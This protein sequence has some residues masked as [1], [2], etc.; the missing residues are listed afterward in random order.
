M[1]NEK[2]REVHLIAKTLLD[3]ETLEIEQIKRLIENGTL[4]GSGEG[5]PS[6]LSKN[7]QRNL[8]L[9]RLAA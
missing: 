6:S 3:E 7:Q 8:S 5:E 4:D 9:I 1:L 2:S